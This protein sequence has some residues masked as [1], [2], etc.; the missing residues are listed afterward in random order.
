MKL[1]VEKIL[2]NLKDIDEAIEQLIGLKAISKDDFIKSMEHKYIAYAGFIILTEAVIDI[3]YHISAKLF[4]KAPTAYAECFELLK[5]NDI[6]NP[7]I[8]DALSDMAR[9]RNLLI[10]RYKKV[11]Y[12]RVYDYIS[13]S[14]QVMNVFKEKI[15]SLI[16]SV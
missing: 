5:K 8:A 15:K 7:E 1:N 12:G 2:G 4:K 11:D 10:H 9:F 14:L 16:A 13:E 6:L 3:C